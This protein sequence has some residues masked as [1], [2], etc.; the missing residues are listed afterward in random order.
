MMKYADAHVPK[1]KIQIHATWTPRGK[2]SRPKSHS[3]RK[4]DSRKKARRPSMA[5][6]APK[7]SPTN[8][9][10]T[11]QFMPNWNSCTMPVTMPMAKLMMSRDPK[12]R[13][14][15]R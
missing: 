15:L 6:G 9:L 2:R 1:V 4:V 14:S 10:K 7:T 12:N 13:A 3:P 11:D 8:R 5:R